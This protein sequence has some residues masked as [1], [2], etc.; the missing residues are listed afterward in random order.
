[1]RLSELTFKI[2]KMKM[3]MRCLDQQIEGVINSIRYLRDCSEV[4]PGILVA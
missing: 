1:M 4:I 2:S 3:E